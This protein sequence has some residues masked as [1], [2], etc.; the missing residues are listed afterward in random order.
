[1]Y[2]VL[3]ELQGKSTLSH[4]LLSCHI[5]AHKPGRQE[6]WLIHPSHSP[7]WG[8]GAIH[9]TTLTKPRSLLPE[10]TGEGLQPIQS[11]AMTLA[12][13]WQDKEGGWAGT[14]SGSSRD[15]EAG[16]KGSGGTQGDSP[17]D[18]PTHQCQSRGGDQPTGPSS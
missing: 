17:W 11:S 8:C 10:L 7:V 12:L 2:P 6:C 15:S 14:E 1:V 13:G 3:P 9:P 18:S 4:G 16:K 5:P